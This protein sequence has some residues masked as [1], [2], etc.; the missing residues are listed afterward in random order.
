MRKEEA[1]EGQEDE[2]VT[3]FRWKCYLRVPAQT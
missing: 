2:L 1:K 3:V